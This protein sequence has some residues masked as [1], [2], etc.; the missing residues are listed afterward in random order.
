MNPHI[1]TYDDITKYPG[2]KRYIKI[3]IKRIHITQKETDLTSTIV[4]S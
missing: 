1:N 2:L 4:N 3:P